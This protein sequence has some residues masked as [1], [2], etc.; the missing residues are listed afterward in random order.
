MM[1]LENF[2]PEMGFSLQTHG[3]ANIDQMLVDD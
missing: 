2:A 1:S 3:D